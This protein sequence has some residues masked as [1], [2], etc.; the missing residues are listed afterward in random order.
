[1]ERLDKIKRFLKN[2]FKESIQA[3]STRN[4]VGDFMYTIYYN[5]GVQI[6]YAPEYEYIEIFG[7]TTEEFKKLQD[8][9]YI[10]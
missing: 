2:N 1:M 8:E 5:D 3:F 10:Y 9:K 6:D 4:L 7:L